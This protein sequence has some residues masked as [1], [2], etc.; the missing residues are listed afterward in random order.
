MSSAVM[1]RAKRTRLMV[2]LFATA[3]LLL[4]VVANWHLVHVA[5][6]SQPDCVAHVRVGAADA[7][8]G[9]FSAAQS[10]CSP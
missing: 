3:G 8:H 10:S 6:T 4:V 7:G 2:W 5:F 9:T 1:T